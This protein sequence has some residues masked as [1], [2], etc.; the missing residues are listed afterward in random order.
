MNASS[1]VLLSSVTDPGQGYGGS[2]IQDLIHF[3]V[4]GCLSLK[5]SYSYPASRMQPAEGL[6]AGCCFFLTNVRRYS[7]HPAGYSAAVRA[8]EDY[9]ARARAE[10]DTDEPSIEALQTLLL[11]AMAN[12][13]SGRG[14]KAYM[15]LSKLLRTNLVV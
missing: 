6:R 9:A 13:Q 4:C 7:S 5:I 15:L 3:H 14:K 12:Y 8:S 11:L 10:L 2:P 1:M